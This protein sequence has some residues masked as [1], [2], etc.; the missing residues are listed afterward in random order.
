MDIDAELYLIDFG[1]DQDGPV[2]VHGKNLPFQFGHI[3][4]ISANKESLHVIISKDYTAE[5]LLAERQGRTWRQR[6]REWLIGL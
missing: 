2:Q 1:H 4:H 5:A 6:F 3:R